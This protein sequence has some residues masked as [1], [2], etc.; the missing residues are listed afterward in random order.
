MSPLNSQHNNVS[1]QE[2]LNYF[3]DAYFLPLKNA[4]AETLFPRKVTLVD[5][6]AE[7]FSK[8]PVGIYLHC[9]PV[10]ATLDVYSFPRTKDVIASET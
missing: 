5:L 3:Q 6:S 9:V 10:T 4:F 8:H 7:L 1:E 2:I